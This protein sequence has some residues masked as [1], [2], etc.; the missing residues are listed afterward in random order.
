MK[1]LLDQLRGDWKLHSGS[2]SHR[3]MPA[4]FSYRFGRWVREQPTP[5]RWVGGKIYGASILASEAIS[6]IYLDRDTEVGDGLHFVHAGGINIHPDAKIGDRVGI[7][8]G[9]TL[10]TGPDGGAPV[11][12]DE[13]FIGANASVLGGV[14]IGKGARVA[15]NSLVVR[16]VPPGALAIGV[17]AKVIPQ[18]K[19]RLK[20]RKGDAAEDG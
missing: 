19:T 4:L 6:G 12:E 11:L 7:M 1:K 20:A 13:V 17:P 10:G 15:A 8:H 5:V 2:G 18:L 16:D 14:R 9:V 3:S